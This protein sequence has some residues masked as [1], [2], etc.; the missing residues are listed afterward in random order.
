MEAANSHPADPADGGG[1][2][3]RSGTE[4]E[5]QTKVYLAIR[6]ERRQA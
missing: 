2:Q 3:N 1:A 5:L 4:P 6:G